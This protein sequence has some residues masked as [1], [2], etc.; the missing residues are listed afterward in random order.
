MIDKERGNIIKM[1]RHMYVKVAFHGS[2]QMDRNQR[3]DAYGYV[4]FLVIFA[5]FGSWLAQ[6]YC[7]SL[8]MTVV[9][10]CV[11]IR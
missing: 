1:D 9:H 7:G 3:R 2:R 10:S 5:N 6:N 11:Y 8:A 4:F